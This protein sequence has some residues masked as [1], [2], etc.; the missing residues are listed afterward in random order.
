MEF[1]PD[2]FVEVLTAAIRAK[3]PFNVGLREMTEWC[4]TH[5]P[6]DD[7]KKIQALDTSEDE[8][9]ALQWIPDVLKKCPCPFDIHA[10]YFG[11][12][13]MANSKD[14]EFADL[15]VGFLGQYDPSDKEAQWVFGENRHYPEK[16]SFKV[17]TLKAAGLIFNCESGRGLGNEGNYMFSLS[18]TLLLVTSLMTPDLYAK[19]G[20]QEERIGI[21]AGWDSGDLMRPGELTKTGFIANEEE[22]I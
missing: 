8:E 19:I 9:K 12:A 15:Y 2:M 6:H 17:K 13:E 22:M 14:E 16:G 20:T 11:L 3:K 7:W 1:D 4:S 18:Y 5:L 10:L 21:L